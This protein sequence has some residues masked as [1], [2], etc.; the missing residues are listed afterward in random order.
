LKEFPEPN[1]AWERDVW[2]LSRRMALLYYHM[3][4]A[5]VERLGKEEGEKLI[6]DAV[7]RYGEACGK[8]VGEEV[9]A[10]GLPLDAAN[11]GMIPDL[12]SRGWREQTVELPEGRSADAVVLCPLAAVWKE[13]GA[14]DLG[15]LY[16][17]VDQAKIHAYN[18]GLRA[19]HSKNVLDGDD[20]CVI[21]I[22]EGGKRT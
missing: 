14:T 2:L 22:E 20:Y 15:R 12:P 10:R 3:A 7:W 11:F 1:D 5:I 18:P 6:S 13:I 16:C 9:L 17:L 19:V 21:D 8:R 4:K